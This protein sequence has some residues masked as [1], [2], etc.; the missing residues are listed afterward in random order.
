MLLYRCQNAEQNQGMKIDNRS[1]ENVEHSKYLG[2]TVTNQ[3]LTQDDIKY[4]LNS[5]NGCYY[6]VQDLSSSRLLSKNVNIKI[7]KTLILPVVLYGYE[8][9]PLII[10]G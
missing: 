2:T 7:Y 5:S 3:N 10:R 8:T 6:S 9:W 4:R 1:F